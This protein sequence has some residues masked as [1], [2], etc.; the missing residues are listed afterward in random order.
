MSQNSH[1]SSSDDD[2]AFNEM[3]KQSTRGYNTN[4]D[5][6]LKDFEVHL[7]TS[8]YFRESTDLNDEG[9]TLSG[10]FKNVF[11]LR[12]VSGIG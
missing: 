10:G 9:G 3:L 6:Y 1:G 5:D 8:G 12:T 2:N 7:D 4:I 11:G